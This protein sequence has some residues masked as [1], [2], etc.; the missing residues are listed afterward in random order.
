M[1]VLHFRITSNRE[2]IDISRQIHSQNFTW[3]RAIVQ[4]VPAAAGTKPNGG[5][6]NIDCGFMQGYEVTSNVNANRLI[7]GLDEEQSMNDRRFEQNFNAEDVKN[8][9]EVEVY[10]FT[11]TGPAVFG[12]G[13]GE[14]TSIDLFFEFTELAPVSY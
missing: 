4:S 1:P 13:A 8:R 9:F 11:G 7:I 5:G 6:L 12:T 2:N 10:N 14:L 3:V